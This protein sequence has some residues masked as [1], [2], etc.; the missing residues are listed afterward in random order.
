MKRLEPILAVIAAISLILKLLL[1]PYS[2][3]VFTISLFTLGVMYFY[4]GWMILNGIGIRSVFKRVYYVGLSP[5][6]IISTIGLGVGI[7]FMCSGTLHKINSWAIANEM[8]VIG[9]VVTTTAVAILHFKSLKS[10]GKQ[11]RNNT[12]RVVVVACLALLS[13]S[14]SKLTFAKINYKDHPGFLKAYENYLDNP[15]SIEAYRKY[16][17]ERNRMALTEYQ[18]EQYMKSINESDQE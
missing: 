13:L 11:L 10:T 15:D 9:L 4:A 1:V 2:G 12:R 3:T 8:I 5:L 16:D 7:G 6:R 14:V 17:I 18:F